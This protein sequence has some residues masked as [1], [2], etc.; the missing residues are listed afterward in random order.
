MEPQEIFERIIELCY[1]IDNNILTGAVSQI[2][3]MVDESA[4]EMIEALEEKMIIL[5]D[6]SGE[7]KYVDSLIVK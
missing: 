3:D 7:D 4:E 2:E 5:E 6:L 1:E